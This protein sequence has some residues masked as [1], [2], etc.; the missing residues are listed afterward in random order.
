MGEAVPLM[1]H[2]SPSDNEHNSLSSLQSVCLVPA[3]THSHEQYIYSLG[4][5]YAKM[6][7]M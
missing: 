4:V 2:S 5:S 6:N 1:V 3:T 7:L